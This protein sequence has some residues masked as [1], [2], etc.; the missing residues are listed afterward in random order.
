MVRKSY[1]PQLLPPG[2]GS[3]YC[4]RKRD[5]MRFDGNGSI[6][7]EDKRREEKRDGRSENFAAGREKKRDM[8]K[9]F[10]QCSNRRLKEQIHHSR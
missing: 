9:D 6:K 4:Q 10:V 8:F 2:R 1:S 7:W 5:E 3:K